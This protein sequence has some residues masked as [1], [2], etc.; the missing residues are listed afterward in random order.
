M[1]GFSMFWRIERRLLTTNYGRLFVILLALGAGAAV[2]SALLN[3]QMDAKKRLTTEFR[4]LGA[5]VIVT[6][7]QTT[8]KD[9]AGT[10]LDQNLLAEIPSVYEGKPVLAVGFL[11]V[12]GE[13]AKAGQVHF[14]P[15]VIAGTEGAGLTQVRPGKRTE[16]LA[17][18]ESDPS[19]CEVG[20]KAAEQFKVHAGDELQL[21]NQGKSASCKVFAVVATGGAED[22]QVFTKLKTA[23]ELSDLKGR[24]SLIQLSVT[25][26]PDS[27]RA[28]VA[29]LGQKLPDASVGG[30]KQFAE[31]ESR[32]YN[33]ISGLLT[34]TVLLVLLLTSLC[35]MAGMS[36]VAV[37]RKN[38]VGLMKAIGGSVRRVV[39]LFLTEAILLGIG[40]GLIGSAVG[41]VVSIWLGKT[42]FGVAAQPR[43]IVYPLSVSLTV[44]VSILSAFP[45]R[46][47]A[48]IRPAS[49][50]RGEE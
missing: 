29:A 3:L 20:V 30:I 22:T 23:Q 13:V 12:I 44:I 37:E 10:T 25:A 9:A 42:V 21:R 46:R 32:I 18:L 1:A 43:W 15:A 14:E 47:L 4:A 34:S 11:Y 50:F 27:V 16:Y 7:R 35:V 26:T 36:N 24:L 41:I 19:A 49:V 5:N 8:D 31:A 33:R 17:N 2:T 40:G 6:P 38:D 45:L 28:F 48:S 39:R